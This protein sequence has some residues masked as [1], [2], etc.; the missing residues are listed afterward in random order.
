MARVVVATMT[1]SGWSGE[2]KCS[3]D[4]Q[5]LVAVQIGVV[6]G[7]AAGERATQIA[8]R[9]GRVA[10]R[11][12]VDRGLRGRHAE[13]AGEV[14][15]AAH[16]LALLFAEDDDLL[17]GVDELLDQRDDPVL[18]GALA[19]LRLD[20]GLELL[21]AVAVGRDVTEAPVLP[22]DSLVE[23]NGPLLTPQ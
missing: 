6:E 4:G 2:R 11:Q 8:G 21:G 5:A 10:G 23:R 17:A 16:R 13:G 14:G 19:P 9:D 3:S 7:H 20:E 22:E 15:R 1:C 12:R 18:A